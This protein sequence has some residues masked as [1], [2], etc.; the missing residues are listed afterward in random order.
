M[1]AMKCATTTLHEQLEEQVGIFM[2][3]P[4]EP[5]FFSDDNQFC[6]GIDWY[7][8]LFEAA[9]E[10]DICG[11]SSTHYTKLPTYPNTVK[12]LHQHL[13]NVKLIY[14]MRHPVD[15]LISQYIHEWSQNKVPGDL[16]QALKQHP[17][18]YEYSLYSRQLQPYLETFG[19]ENVL[20]VF[21]ERLRQSPNEEFTRICKFIGYDQ[22]AHWLKDLKHQ[23][24]SKARLRKSSWRDAIVN[25][26]ILSS[27][28]RHWVPQSFRDW[29][30]GF[31]QM[32]HRPQLSVQDRTWLEA[33]FDIDL[34]ILGDWLGMEL[35]CK[36]FS[37]AA[38]TSSSVGWINYQPSQRVLQPHPYK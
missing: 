2:S 33:K 9:S 13:P 1:G 14:V 5:N 4:K 32:Q 18:L 27:I 12:R 28:R 22:P 11:E 15:R 20:P 6:R 38:L 7:S 29:V 3:H 36:N 26:P 35:S 8:G 10:G 17:E 25:A 24:A 34:A 31:W 21:F 37:T 30:K 23:H 19:P 16:S